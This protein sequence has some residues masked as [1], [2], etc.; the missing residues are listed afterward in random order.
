MA[1]QQ[2]QNPGR[3]PSQSD[4]KQG[5]DETFTT[6]VSETDSEGTTVR[7]AEV[8]KDDL[9]EVDPATRKDQG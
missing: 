9:S 7:E 6:D 1:T 5:S 2:Q 3:Q 4:E 8:R